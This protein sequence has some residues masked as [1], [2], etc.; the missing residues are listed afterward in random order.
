MGAAI[1]FSQD[2]TVEKI[3][4]KFKST[5]VNSSYWDAFGELLDAVFLPGYP[6]L[7]EVIKSEEGEYLKFYSFVELGRQDFNLAVK[8]IRNYISEQ[9]NPTEWQKM[10]QV[11]WKEIAEPYIVQDDRYEPG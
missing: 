2:N 3:E 5:Y 1:I 9:Q 6:K 10:A 7:H 11:V 8:L 4:D